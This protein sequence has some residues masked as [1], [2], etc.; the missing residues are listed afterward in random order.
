[1]SQPIINQL[2]NDIY[3]TQEN[4]CQYRFTN[5]KNVPIII[6]S[7]KKINLQSAPV[8]YS[9]I[10]KR[11]NNVSVPDQNVF[12]NIKKMIIP[13]KKNIT[14]GKTNNKTEYVQNNGHIKN[15]SY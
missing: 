6:K 11:N 14:Y 7:K 8:K 12:Y 5:P 15:N 10:I 1:M 2:F 4:N 13:K 3:N 9:Q